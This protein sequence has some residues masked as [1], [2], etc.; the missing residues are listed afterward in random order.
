MNGT[1]L[2]WVAVIVGSCGAVWALTPP[3]LSFL[4]RSGLKYEPSDDPALAAAGT[5]DADYEARARELAELGF[6]PVG[7]VTETMICQGFEWRSQFFVRVWANADRTCYASL[8]RLHPAEAVRVSL[9][10][11]T[12]EEG[13]VCAA[14]PGAGLLDEQHNYLRREY[15]AGTPIHELLERHWRDVEDFCRCREV[16]PT[17]G[18]LEEVTRVEQLHERRQLK[19]IWGGHAA[20]APAEVFAVPCLLLLALRTPVSVGSVGV[21]L[22]G[23]LLVF[24]LFR[25]AVAHAF[26][27]ELAA[28]NPPAAAERW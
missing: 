5:E 4:G 2:E 19:A 21:A 9:K 15:P 14:C 10:S 8:Y 12:T 24:A 28:S 16:R 22:C 20:L 3:L 1:V 7:A 23:G 11:M 18:S 6:E 25:L 26:G 17:G 13:L 27:R